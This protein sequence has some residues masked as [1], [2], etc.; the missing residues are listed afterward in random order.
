MKSKV[1]SKLP[2]NKDQ[3]VI[4]IMTT[5]NTFDATLLI[6]GEEKD[7]SIFF[8]QIRIRADFFQDQDKK[9]TILNHGIIIG[10][11]VEDYQYANYHY[12]PHH[13]TSYH[14]KPEHAKKFIA[15]I[16]EDAK[17][18]NAYRHAKAKSLQTK[19]ANPIKSIIFKLSDIDRLYNKQTNEINC[20]VWCIHKLFST[21]GIKLEKP[22]VS[23]SNQLLDMCYEYR[24]HLFFSAAVATTIAWT[25]TS[26]SNLA[27]NIRQLIANKDIEDEGEI[28]LKP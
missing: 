28:M 1:N 4:S 24:Y 23:N 22:A 13:S 14:I 7:G 17:K 16:K 2:I 18:V 19:T 11:E 21:E 12:T 26:Q 9:N 15:I 27:K 3:W 20:D 5:V 8:R 25:A 6:E 10:I